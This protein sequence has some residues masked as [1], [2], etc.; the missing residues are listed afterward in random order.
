MNAVILSIGDELVLGQ[1]I[2]TNSA[3]LSAQL[4]AIG[5]DVLA[6][7]TIPDSQAL[8][9]QAIRRNVPHCDVLLISGGLGP[10]EDDLTRQAMAGAMG[11]E[12]VLCEAWVPK[13]EAFF[14]LRN[15]PMPASNRIQAML[16]QGA[17]MIDNT[18]GTACGI[19][20]RMA[21][22]DIYVMPGVPREMK[23]M[24]ARDVLPQLAARSAGRI[25]LSR[26]L[27]TFG[28]G[29]SSVGVLLGDL[30][31]RRRN[32][33]VGTTVSAGLVSIRINARFDSLTQAQ[34]QLAQTEAACRQRLADLVY[35]T[36][37]ATLPQAIAPLLVSHSKTIATAESCT[38]GLLAAMFTEVPGSSRYFRQGW[39]TY[40][41]QSKEQLLGVCPGTLLA[42]GAV[43]EPTVREMA[44]AA[45]RL[46]GADF[47][48]S[49]SGI[50]GPDGGTAEKPVGT[51]CFGF[52]H[53]D[54]T[55]TY[56]L[57]MLGE[58]DMIRDRACKTAMTILRYH[59][60]EKPLPF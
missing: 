32:P 21:S 50:A 17:R 40:S 59:L 49:I 13:L 47:A 55:S 31:D 60:I 27:H 12:L 10:T 24:F 37:G 14:R 1:T 34:D 4:A 6:H 42:H 18:C 51:V 53:P 9:E 2:D 45:R 15:R 41:N 38:G 3:W 22:C 36:D 35:G 26:T 48:L 44:Q 58:R 43:S 28:L 8:T 7:I 23:I 20:A 57:P 46:A 54:G 16:P 52:A 30:M 25:I 39:V 11:V 29:E 19:A 56:T 5:C 33:S